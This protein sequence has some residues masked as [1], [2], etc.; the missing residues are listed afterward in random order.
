MKSRNYALQFMTNGQFEPTKAPLKNQHAMLEEYLRIS[1]AY[2]K[3]KKKWLQ[4]ESSENI[5]IGY[6][7]D[8]RVQIPQIL[9]FIL[10]GIYDA[11][12]SGVNHTTED[13]HLNNVKNQKDFVIQRF[14]EQEI[15]Y[16]FITFLDRLVTSDPKIKIMLYLILS[17][18]D[19]KEDKTGMVEIGKRICSWK[20]FQEKIA[21]KKDEFET[22]ISI[23]YYLVVEL[24]QFC[25]YKTFIDDDWKEM[26]IKCYQ[27]GGF[28]KNLCENN[29]IFFKRYLSTIK[30][31]LNNNNF[32]QGSNLVYDYY[33]RQ[34][35][36]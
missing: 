17:K 9:I 15:P 34:E 13:D 5:L 12:E 27:L 31:T 8:N 22:V 32:C 20:E 29:S 1:K 11:F 25:M 3:D 21:G 7:N 35:Q 23:I 24:E 33:I 10:N 16:G 18:I 30:P 4:K 19:A 26:W 36:Q 6:L 14:F 2:S 28:F